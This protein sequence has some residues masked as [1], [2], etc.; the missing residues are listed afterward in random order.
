MVTDHAA[1]RACAANTLPVLRWQSRQWQTETPTG[2][3]DVVALSWPQTQ[4][5]VRFV[6]SILF[7]LP[8]LGIVRIWCQRFGVARNE[9]L[10]LSRECARTEMRVILPLRKID[11]RYECPLPEKPGA[12]CGARYDSRMKRS[13][14][15]MRRR[16]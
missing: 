13:S 7:A 11:L 6:S 5:A 2:A 16:R 9:N 4:L 14:A 10:G 15:N 3:A 12:R 8:K 1:N